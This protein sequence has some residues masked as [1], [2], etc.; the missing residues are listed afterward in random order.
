M[1]SDENYT[2]IINEQNIRSS[3]PKTNRPSNIP[4]GTD[5]YILSEVGRKNRE[6]F[7]SKT[8]SIPTEIDERKL[9]KPIQADMMKRIR[10][11]AKW[12][13]LHKSGQSIPAKV[14]I[15]ELV[16][17]IEEELERN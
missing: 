12:S 1:N 9:L 15:L 13:Q 16:D 10:S 3:L 17:N 4:L 11:T 8:G 5:E 14:K 2:K 6:E 7:L